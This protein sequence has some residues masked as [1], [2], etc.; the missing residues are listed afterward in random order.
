M[1]NLDLTTTGS[2]PS[3]NMGMLQNQNS[4]HG[5]GG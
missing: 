1:T 2:L 4:P 5:G 3:P